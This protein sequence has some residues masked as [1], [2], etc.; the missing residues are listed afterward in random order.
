MEAVGVE[1][2]T[3]IFEQ[4]KGYL[5]GERVIRFAEVIVAKRRGK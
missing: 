5:L 3:I 2:N 1:E 4:L